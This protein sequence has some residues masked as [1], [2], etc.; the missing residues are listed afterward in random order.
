MAAN[1][2]RVAGDCSTVISTTKTRRTRRLHE[3]AALRNLRAFDLVADDG[4]CESFVPVS[5]FVVE[6]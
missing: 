1:A 4:L 2:A 3:G 6:L 5:V